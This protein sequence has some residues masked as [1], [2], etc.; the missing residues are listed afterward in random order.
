LAR[1]VSPDR[2]DLSGPKLTEYV[3]T[4]WYRAPEVMLLSAEYG[5]SIDVWAVGCTLA[6]TITRTAL[7]KGKDTL[8]QVGQIFK[9]LGMPASTELQWLSK[10]SAALRFINRF[11]DQKG[12]PLGSLMPQ[13]SPDALDAV[14]QM[15]QLDPSRRPSAK[16]CMRLPLFASI[17]QP[18][19]ELEVAE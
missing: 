13:A 16:E 7:F 11:A 3:V 14:Q 1:S 9:V 17:H 10:S 5:A 6:E 2:R 19:D 4:R 18:S 12:Q 8:D 15:L